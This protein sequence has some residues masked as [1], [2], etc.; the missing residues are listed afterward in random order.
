MRFLSHSWCYRRDILTGHCIG[1]FYHG[2]RP[3][4]S[5]VTGIIDEVHP[6]RSKRPH[7]SNATFPSV[8]WPSNLLDTLA[9]DYFT[10]SFPSPMGRLFVVGVAL[11]T[12]LVWVSLA[13]VLLST[14][15]WRRYTGK[16]T[17]RGRAN[18]TRMAIGMSCGL[19]F[20]LV[21]FFSILFYYF[22]RSGQDLILPSPPRCPSLCVCGSLFSRWLR[23]WIIDEVSGSW[24]AWSNSHHLLG[25]SPTTH[26]SSFKE[27]RCLWFP[28]QSRS[29][30]HGSRMSSCEPK[31]ALLGQF[32]RY[33]DQNSI[34]FY[35]LSLSHYS[36]A[37]HS[38]W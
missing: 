8:F 13:F 31:L 17:E 25:P 3:C 34:S 30:R 6:N 22:I 14:S 27:A 32:A 11:A 10:P 4:G 21:A 12:V 24:E 1:W 18:P 28:D 20:F 2:K 5:F 29:S 15:L 36:I 19:F 37:I 35:S 7:I 38:V 23:W 26:S 16:V 9:D 33:T